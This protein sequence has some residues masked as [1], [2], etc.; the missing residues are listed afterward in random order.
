MATSLSKEA[1]RGLV[2]AL[3]YRTVEAAEFQRALFNKQPISHILKLNI[4]DAMARKEEAEEVINC[5]EHCGYILSPKALHRFLQMLGG[6]GNLDTAA[7]I[8]EILPLL[9]AP[10]CPLSL[11]L[12]AG[13]H[14]VTPTWASALGAISY[15]LYYNTTGSPTLLSTKVA[16]AVSGVPVTGLT[17]GVTYFFIVTAVDALGYE[18]QCL[19]PVISAM[20]IAPMMML[21]AYAGITNVGSSVITG[22]IGVFNTDTITGFPPGMVSG[23]THHVDTAA[24]DAAALQQ[25]S[26]TA[27]QTLGLA[28]TTIDSELGGQTLTPGAY[29][30]ASGSAGLSLTTGGGISPLTFNGAGTYIIYTASTLLTGASGSTSAPVMAFLG[31]ATAADIF[32]IVGSSATINQ[33]VESAGSVFQG[34]IIAAESI[35]VPQDA[36]MHG[37]YTALTGAISFAAAAIVEP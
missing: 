12:V 23:I 9:Q 22:D 13:N 25:A 27:K 16:N 24:S 29:K 7:A 18:S 15:N 26:F 21:L 28:G 10:C 20:P 34:N 19:A 4:I 1:F 8:R 30:F 2:V 32:W 3:G 33:A 35:S 37:N 6:R 11:V 5:L 17:D 36:T 14:Q 31:G